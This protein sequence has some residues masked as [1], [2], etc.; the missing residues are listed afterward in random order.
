MEIKNVLKFMNLAYQEATTTESHRKHETIILL[1][2]APLLTIYRR[3]FLRN[4]KIIH[5]R[6]FKFIRVT[7][8]LKRK[9]H[10]DCLN[11]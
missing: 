7:L 1:F 5:L 3:V 4:S 11:L 2:F 8:D 9:F 6:Q 10:T